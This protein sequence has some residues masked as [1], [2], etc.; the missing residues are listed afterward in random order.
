M[1]TERSFDGSTG[2]LPGDTEYP[3]EHGQAAH[4]A[5]AQPVEPAASSL[6]MLVRAVAEREEEDHGESLLPIEIADIG[7]R[8]QCR[9]DFP[10]SDWMGWQKLAIP[11]EKR[12]KP[13]PTD[14]RQDVLCT[15]VLLNTCEYLEI[16]SG[17]DW[18]PVTNVAGETLAF[19][20]RELRDKFS[21]MDGP[22]LVQRLFAGRDG[23]IIRAG[24]RVVAAA[25]YGDEADEREALEGDATEGDASPLN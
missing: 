20:S 6:D 25:G 21:V 5:E 8:M 24:M 13:Q 1:T 9:I 10:Y 3:Y 18:V 14:L 2:S 12:R 19:E 4:Y 17:S 16:K 15:H 11:R 7:V 23:H 22:S